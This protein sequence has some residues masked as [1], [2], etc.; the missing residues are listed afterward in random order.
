MADA[1]DPDLAQQKPRKRRAHGVFFFSFFGLLFLAAA[2]LVVGAVTRRALGDDLTETFSL[3]VS[4]T[5]ATIIALVLPLALIIKFART[6]TGAL[7]IFCFWNLAVCLAL[8]GLTPTLSRQ[9]LEAHGD[10]PARLVNGDA[11]TMGETARFLAGYLPGEP[12]PEKIDPTPTDPAVKPVPA[13]Q[14]L[15]APVPPFSAEQLFTVAA[16]SVVFIGVRRP[17]EPGSMEAGIASIIGIKELEGHGSG[18]VVSA[19]GLIVTNHHVAGEAKSVSVRTR[20]GQR[21]DQVSLLALDEGNDLALIKVEAKDLRPLALYDRSKVPVGTTAFAIGSPL[22]LDFTL[23]SGI[24]SASRKQQKT[25]LLQMQTAIAPGSSGGPLLD[26]H[27]RLIGVNTATSGFAGLNLAV[28]VKHVRKLLESPRRERKL[29]RWQQGAEVA[30]FE[31]HGGQLLP[32][33]RAG[34]DRVAKLAVKMLEGCARTAPNDGLRIVLTMPAEMF[35]DPGIDANLDESTVGCMRK[36]LG[37]VAMST[38]AMLQKSRTVTRIDYHFKGLRVGQAAD[39]GAGETGAS[40][41]DE[42]TT[43]LHLSLIPAWTAR[44]GA[45]ATADHEQDEERAHPGPEPGDTL[46]KQGGILGALNRMKRE[47]QKSKK[48]KKG[49]KG[50]KSRKRKR[51]KQPA[52][53]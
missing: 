30:G 9:A 16:D 26:D 15:V 49:K 22:G 45:T 1:P 7:R 14:P 33:D 24:V 27:A 32:T 48:G 4:A 35:G 51:V 2:L 3:W 21:F 39:G 50:K 31:L 10:W 12:L 41:T 43:E 28:H 17:I 8:C 25:T 47:P 42:T 38:T 6:A 11:E 40:G 29:K 52:I 5:G 34:L 53:D 18:F 36:G 13:S 20:G 19:D 23:T 37:I 46:E 44:Q